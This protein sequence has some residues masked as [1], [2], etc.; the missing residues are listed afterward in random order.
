MLANDECGKMCKTTSVDYVNVSQYMF[1]SHRNFLTFVSE[2]P[3][4]RPR[5]EILEVRGSV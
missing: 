3:V 2:L 4:P 5:K 1:E